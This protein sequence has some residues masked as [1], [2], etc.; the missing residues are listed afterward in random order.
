LCER[1]HGQEESGAYEVVY[2]T[3]N[4]ADGPVGWAA[5]KQKEMAA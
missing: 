3:A 5:R 4:Y 2:H 1:H